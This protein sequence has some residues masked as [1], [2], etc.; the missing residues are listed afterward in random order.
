M[1]TPDPDK[2]LM[3]F[4]PNR[5]Q[6]WRDMLL[7]VGAACLLGPLVGPLVV[8]WINPTQAW[9]VGEVGDYSP[10]SVLL[11]GLAFLMF[12]A[13]FYVGWLMSRA[14]RGWHERTADDWWNRQQ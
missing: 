1:T 3:N 2:T 12:E 6:L 4:L 11:W 14:R 10:G 8:S 5:K 9:G 7:L 13:F